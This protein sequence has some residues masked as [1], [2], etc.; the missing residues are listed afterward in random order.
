VTIA[1][2]SGQ[3]QGT[4]TGSCIARAFRT[5]SV[6]PFAGEPVTVTKDVA[7]R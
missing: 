2:I 1:R 6:P 7:I 3:F 5:V 4:P